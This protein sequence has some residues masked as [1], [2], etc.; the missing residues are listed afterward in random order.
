MAGYSAIKFK[1]HCARYYPYLPHC[2]PSGY[3]KIFQFRQKL[4]HISLSLLECFEPPTFWNLWNLRVSENIHTVTG[5]SYFGNSDRWLSPRAKLWSLTETF[6]GVRR[7]V[8]V[9]DKTKPRYSPSANQQP[10]ACS[11]RRVLPGSFIIASKL[12]LAF[13][14]SFMYH[15]WS[16]GFHE[17]V[18]TLL[19]NTRYT[20]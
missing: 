15:N 11:D 17:T 18:L 3:G 9:P 6:R 2:N 8:C 12:A 1:W 13:G 20:K 10:K 19:I 16:N 5:R 4:S 14:R 7:V